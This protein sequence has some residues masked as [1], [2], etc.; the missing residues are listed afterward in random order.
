MTQ[1]QF[2][3]IS[4]LLS[5]NQF[6]VI[7]VIADCIDAASTFDKSF[8]PKLLEIIE[9]SFNQNIFVNESI[10]LFRS[11][12]IRCPEIMEEPYFEN[13]QRILQ[14]IVPSGTFAALQTMSDI[15]ITFYDHQIVQWLLPI[16]LKYC[17]L[18]LDF[19]V[20]ILDMFD[21]L[22]TTFDETEFPNL[23][24]DFAFTYL[25]IVLPFCIVKSLDDEVIELRSKLRPSFLSIRSMIDNDDSTR[26]EQFLRMKIMEYQN[27]YQMIEAICFIWDCADKVP[28]EL[29]HVHIY[30]PI[31][32]QSL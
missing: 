7:A 1:N 15:I 29:A 4:Q 21:E 16:I 13:T 11:I 17:Q 25:Q 6:Q 24:S 30:R 22:Y 19:C 10:D 28:P 26:F 20:D 23:Y 2:L 9:I 14:K 27:N 18:S 31:L 3:I 8:L 32:F 5:T 12:L